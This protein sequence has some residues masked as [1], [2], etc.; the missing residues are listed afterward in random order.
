MIW[1]GTS[2]KNSPEVYEKITDVLVIKELELYG[3][4]KMNPPKWPALKTGNTSCVDSSKNVNKK[5][6][7]H[8]FVISQTFIYHTTQAIP[9]FTPKM[10]S[11]TEALFTKV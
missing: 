6:E 9:Q 11:F 10:K 8:P 3:D 2:S 4:S 5:H 1:T 7:N